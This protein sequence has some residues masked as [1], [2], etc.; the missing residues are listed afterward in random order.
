MVDF[1]AL[2]CLLYEMLVGNSPFYHTNQSG[3][4]QNIS[5]GRYN[6]PKDLD[7]DARDLIQKL[8]NLDVSYFK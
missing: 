5:N 4:L 6:M 3:I 7:P 8:L 2:G 1:W